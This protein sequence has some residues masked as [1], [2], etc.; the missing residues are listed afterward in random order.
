[1]TKNR[2][3]IYFAEKWYKRKLETKEVREVFER[4]FYDE[5]FTGHSRCYIDDKGNIERLDPLP[6]FI[7]D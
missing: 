3:R 6:G 5:L 7:L 4:L 2:N 1:M